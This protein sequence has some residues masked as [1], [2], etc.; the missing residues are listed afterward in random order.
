[1]LSEPRFPSGVRYS[2]S[3]HR[4]EEEE[5]EEEEVFICSLSTREAIS[6][7]V[8]PSC[9]HVVRS[10]HQASRRDRTLALGKSSSNSGQAGI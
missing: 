1:M 8:G 6:N 10:L 3:P 9:R 4:A 7:Q 2:R 5:E